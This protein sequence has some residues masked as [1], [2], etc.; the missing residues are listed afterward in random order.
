YQFGPYRAYYEVGRYQ[1]VLNYVANS[2][3]TD[4]GQYVEETYYW[5]G[6]ALAQLGRNN[7]AINS[8]Q[9]ALSQNRF[10]ADARQAITELGG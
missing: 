10:F 1:D 7:E 3:S 5:Q 6:R 8:F 2:L 9:R 4:G